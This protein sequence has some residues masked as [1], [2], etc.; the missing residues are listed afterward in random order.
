MDPG[1]CPPVYPS[2]WHLA[3][4]FIRTC[5]HCWSVC[6]EHLLASAACYKLG[7]VMYSAQHLL[8]KQRC[9]QTALQCRRRI[10][11]CKGACSKLKGMQDRDAVIQS[12][13]QSQLLSSSQLDCQAPLA[14]IWT[15]SQLGM[16]I[17][18]PLQCAHV[19]SFEYVLTHVSHSAS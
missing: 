4:C 18:T 10:S 3:A 8:G 16:C 7:C 15:D 5:P 13:V 14:Q 2:F 1:G 6:C 12:K 17:Q 9:V 19:R 11:C